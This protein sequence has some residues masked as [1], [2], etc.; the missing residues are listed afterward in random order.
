[1]LLLPSS[2][3]DQVTLKVGQKTSKFTH[4]KAFPFEEDSRLVS[5]VLYSNLFLNSAD[6]QV[7]SLGS[8]TVLGSFDKAGNET[9]LFL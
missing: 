9:V 7:P 2:G 5:S 4:R 3:K 6:F 8:H 1:M